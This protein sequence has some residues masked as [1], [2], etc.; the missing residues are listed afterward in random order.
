M[1]VFTGW[2]GILILVDSGSITI[3]VC[4][5]DRKGSEQILQK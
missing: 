2:Y 4:Q 5:Y 3:L 1:T